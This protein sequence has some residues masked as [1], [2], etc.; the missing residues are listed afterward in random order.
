MKRIGPVAILLAWMLPVVIGFG[1]WRSG[2]SGFIIFLA[3]LLG[4]TAGWAL[5]VLPDRRAA[6]SAIEGDRF[7]G[8]ALLNARKLGR[9]DA[10]K[11]TF[12]DAHTGLL[13]YGLAT[14]DLAISDRGVVWVPG[15]MAQM[16][17]LPALIIPP[18]KLR[19]I[20]ILPLPGGREPAKLG[21][22][23]TD[24]TLILFTI[25]RHREL[26]RNLAKD[27]LLRWKLVR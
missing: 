6:L 12:R 18:E 20:R 14:G 10:F 11:E 15:R 23:L 3:L 22:V 17:K 24:E 1:A 9:A 21:V 25:N 27:D 5:V 13:I 8:T 19:E 4:S 7:R 2:A 26:Q 16:L